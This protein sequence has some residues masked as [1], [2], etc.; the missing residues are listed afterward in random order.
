MGNT[1]DDEMAKDA[2]MDFKKLQKLIETCS[3]RIFENKIFIVENKELFNT[4]VIGKDA[5]VRTFEELISEL[6]ESED[7][8][9]S[10]V[11]VHR[12]PYG[13]E[14]EDG[15]E[16]FYPEWNREDIASIK[17]EII[18]SVSEFINKVIYAKKEPNCKVFYRGHENWEYELLPGIY[19]TGNENI[20]LHE[21]EYI[22]EIISSYPQYFTQCKSALDYLSVLQHQGFPTRLLDFS[23]NP[24]IALYMACSNNGIQ[25]ADVI[26]I[27]IPNNYFKYYDSDTVSVLA[28]LAFFDDNFSVTDILNDFSEVDAETFN[29]QPDIIRLVHQI[30]NE[31]PYFKPSIIPNH[32]NG[33]ILFVKPK[34]N[35]D[36]IAHQSGLFAIFGIC[37]RKATMPTIEMMN[38]SCGITHYIIPADLKK[39]VL[40]ELA[41]LNITEASVY[42]DMEH[43]SKYYIEK[44]KNDTI[45]QIIKSEENR[46]REMLNQILSEL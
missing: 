17:I 8:I 27:T 43:I 31:K 19:R 46:D 26:R 3:N 11:K 32:L 42:C 45:E 2:D 4:N 25:H 30:R 44:S 16:V 29:K 39:K 6:L 12:K 20:L 22:R 23:E 36:R 38:P 41:C 40:A 24:L 37:G 28:N 35:F 18:S 13:S 7:A 21:S 1:Y 14:K 33:L 15:F 9:N 5:S 34:Q 10:R